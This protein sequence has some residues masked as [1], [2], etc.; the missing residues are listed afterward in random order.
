MRALVRMNEV[1]RKLAE[2]TCKRVPPRVRRS[3]GR[4]FRLTCAYSTTRTVQTRVFGCNR[5][6][7]QISTRSYVRTFARSLGRVT[8]HVRAYVHTFT[9]TRALTVN[10]SART[11]VLTDT[12][13][14][15]TVTRAGGCADVGVAGLALW[16]PRVVQATFHPSH[17]IRA[18]HR[19]HWGP[20]CDTIHPWASTA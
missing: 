2:R 6:Y 15:L 20:N 12:R 18:S 17:V 19:A 8:S 16:Q 4:S 3:T 1:R 14:R 10:S 9:C 11:H 7:G 13:A 5:T